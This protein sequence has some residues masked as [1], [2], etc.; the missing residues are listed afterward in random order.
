MSVSTTL[1]EFRVD[2]WCDIIQLSDATGLRYYNDA[3]DELIDAITKEKENFFYNSVTTS[4]VIGQN[5][6]RF[7]KRWDLAQDW[8]TI[9]DGLQKIKWVSWKIKTTD[10]EYT[11]LRPTT[12]ENL[13]KDIESYDE[14]ANPFYCVMDNSI[15]IYPA[16]EEVSELKI[17][18]I[19]YPK[20][21]ALVDTETL[22]DQHIK[23]I[24]YGVKKRFLESQTRVQES[25]LADAKFEQEKTKVA[26]A[27]SGRIQAPIQR[28]TPNLNYLS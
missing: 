2:M 27:L 9:L 16:P 13:E 23:A 18:A 28:S 10:E 5:E 17:Y 12:L 15:F 20:K 14:T 21:L 7:P 25:Q 26:V 8:V 11:V 4:T 6:Y 22:P 3:R 1:A 19:M 24:L